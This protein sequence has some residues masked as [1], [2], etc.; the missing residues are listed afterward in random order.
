MSF[1]C[2]RVHD[3]IRYGVLFGHMI[4]S[5]FLECDSNSSDIVRIQTAQPMVFIKV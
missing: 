1:G 3:C 2:K 5:G 4:C